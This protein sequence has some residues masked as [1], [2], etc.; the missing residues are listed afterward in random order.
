MLCHGDLTWTLQLSFVDTTSRVPV[1]IA[2]E[3]RDEMFNDLFTTS[4]ND[5]IEGW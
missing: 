3:C 4:H 5:I 2:A 1:A